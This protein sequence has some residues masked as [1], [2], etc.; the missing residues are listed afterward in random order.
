[1]TESGTEPLLLNKRRAARRIGVSARTQR[2]PT[3]CRRLL[4]GLHNPGPCV[5]PVCRIIP[6]FGRQCKENP[7]LSSRRAGGS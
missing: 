6:A 4:S 1:M 3:H 2:S 7:V 5:P